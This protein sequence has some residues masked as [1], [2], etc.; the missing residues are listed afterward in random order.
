MKKN[1]QSKAQLHWRSMGGTTDLEIKFSATG[2][3]EE[4]KT[5]LKMK[6]HRVQKPSTDG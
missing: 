5:T 3:D 1:D 6:P 2:Q 4:S